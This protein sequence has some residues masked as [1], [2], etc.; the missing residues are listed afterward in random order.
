MNSREDNSA[1]IAGRK[2]PR[3]WT[4]FARTLTPGDTSSPWDVAYSDWFKERLELRYLEPMRRIRVDG[5]FQGEGFAIA[6]LLC[7][8][9]EFLA[10][11]H[12][13]EI[14][15][16]GGRGKPP[17]GTYY[18]S[19]ELYCRFL[20]NVSPFKDHFDDQS[21]EEFFRSV[22]C[23][24]LHEAST[25]NNWKIHA[26]SDVRIL[27]VESKIVQ[28]EALSRVVIEYVDG[29]RALLGQ[30]ERVQAAFIRKF[31]ALADDAI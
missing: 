25:K 18:Q 24:L 17:P 11:N 6:S 9:I 1:A 8:L 13:G 20:V 3:D 4:E 10:A 5:T 30:D 31:S 12:Y 26:T 27:N 2:T 23:G 22:R 19:G 16:P 29:Y 15:A 14:Y 21:A 28:R 7:A